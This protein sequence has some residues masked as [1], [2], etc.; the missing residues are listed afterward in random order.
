MAGREPNRDERG[1]SLIEIMAAVTIFS[2]IVLS[3]VKLRENS[4]EMAFEANRTRIMRYLAAHQLGR[5]EL[6]IQEDGTPYDFT[7]GDWAESGDFSEIGEEYE[8]YFW[9]ATV[10]EVY[11]VGVDSESTE[12]DDDAEVL[13]ENDTVGEPAGEGAP[14]PVKLY[15]IRLAVGWLETPS[16][17]DGGVTS[18]L[19]VGDGD[20]EP[21]PSGASANTFVL[22]TFVPIPPK[23]EEGAIR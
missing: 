23:E 9:T 12:R 18:S 8:T 17:E 2:V 7:S 21:L 16:I 11:V 13:F 20:T 4:Y 1:F 5:L 3:F 10:R 14:E 22:E 6:G 15:R 19:D